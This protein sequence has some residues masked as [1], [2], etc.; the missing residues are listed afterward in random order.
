MDPS[1]V[2]RMQTCSPTSA[3]RTIIDGVGHWTQQEAPAAF[4]EA[5]LGFLTL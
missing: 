2:D 4:N 1:G 3:A 5:L